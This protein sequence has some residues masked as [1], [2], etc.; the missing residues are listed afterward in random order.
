MNKGTG[1]HPQG[2]RWLMRSYGR[3]KPWATRGYYT[4]DEVYRWECSTP[5]RPLYP[6]DI[7][8]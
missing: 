4:R 1:Q 3:W 7:E 8:L 2:V 6:L 5:L